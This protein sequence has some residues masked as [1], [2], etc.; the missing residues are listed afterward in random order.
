MVKKRSEYRKHLKSDRWKQIRQ[1]VMERAG[2]VCE[3]DECART[4]VHVHHETYKNF[5]DEP[6]EDLLAL[7]HRCHQAQHPDRPLGRVRREKKKSIY[8]CPLCRHVSRKARYV[9]DHIAAKHPHMMIPVRAR[10]ERLPA[11]ELRAGQALEEPGL[12]LGWEG[13][14]ITE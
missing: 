7:C 9:L 11:W 13:V 14:E 8:A 4:A 10:G 5:G 1:R 3:Q 2:Y 12:P 6:L